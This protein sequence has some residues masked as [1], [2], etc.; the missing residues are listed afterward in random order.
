MIRYVILAL[1]QKLIMRVV[2]QFEKSTL[3]KLSGKKFFNLK[4]S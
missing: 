3:I 2:L 1:Y 4:F